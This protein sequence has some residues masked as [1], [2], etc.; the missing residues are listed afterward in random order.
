[1]VIHM[2]SDEFEHIL[3]DAIDGDNYALEK[4]FELYEPLIRK[5]SYVKGAYKED[6]HQQLL[7]HIAL[8]IHKFPL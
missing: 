1:M 4:I 3:R 6:L 7:I 8:N 5:Y 2:K